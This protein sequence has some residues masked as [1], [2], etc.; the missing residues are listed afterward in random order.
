MQKSMLKNAFW[1]PFT[2][3]KNII[4]KKVFK[5]L[6]CANTTKA[7]FVKQ[8]ISMIIMGKSLKTVSGR[9]ETVT[10]KTNKSK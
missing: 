9:S 6:A 7:T 2:I 8:P 10:I 1:H 3:V 4:N 5:K